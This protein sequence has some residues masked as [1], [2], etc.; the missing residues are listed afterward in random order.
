MRTRVLPLVVCGLMVLTAAALAGD[1]SKAD[2]NELNKLREEVAKLREKAANAEVEVKLLLD[3]NKRLEERIAELEKDNAR[4]RKEGAPARGPAKAAP[5]G[6]EGL[7]K[8]VDEKSGLVSLSIGS[9]A[10]LEKGH[11]L[12]VYRLKPAPKYLGQ[13]EV[14]DVTPTQAVAR[15]VGKARDA[16][17]QGDSVSS[18]LPKP[19]EEKWGTVKGQVTFEGAVPKRGPE[20]YVVNAKNKGVK[21]VFVWLVDESDP[22]HPKA[23][24]I[25]PALKAGKDVEISIPAGP[26]PRRFVPHAF[27]MRGGQA[28]IMK[29]ATPVADNVK[30]TGGEDAGGD[31]CAVAP[32]T[33]AK[34]TLGASRKPVMVTSNINPGMSAWGRVFD[35]PYFALTD[36]DGKFE[37]KGAPAGKYNIIMWHEGHGWVNGGKHGQPVTIPGGKAVEVNAKAKETE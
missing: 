9:D 24:P 21:N 14:V 8:S 36:A 6:V 32:N 11:T 16:I 17:Q 30:I 19:A 4:L 26:G 1:G 18:G 3:R 31:S 12:E 7:I 5:E 20:E 33:T 22:K 29:N 10:G 25:N 37:I 28:V 35:H 23:P 2:E 34:V 13:V 27:A 15:P